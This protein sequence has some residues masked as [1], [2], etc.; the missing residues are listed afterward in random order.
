MSCFKIKAYLFPF[1]FFLSISFP[2]YSAVT[3]LYTKSQKCDDTALECLNIGGFDIHVSLT[4]PDN[5]SHLHLFQRK[6]AA[7]R[8]PAGYTMFEKGNMIAE[9]YH[10]SVCGKASEKIISNHRNHKK[11][12][13]IFEGQKCPKPGE[14][15]FSTSNIVACT[16][17]INYGTPSTSSSSKLDKAKTTCTELGFTLG[18]EKHGDCVLKLMEN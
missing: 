4:Q 9:P 3:E 18:T 10:I 6:A 15:I 7:F 5:S 1:L 13:Q 14:V 8:C 16:L 11:R 2:T 12:V 17:A